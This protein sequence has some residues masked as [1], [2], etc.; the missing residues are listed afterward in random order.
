MLLSISMR[1]GILALNTC[2]CHSWDVS[3]E[4]NDLHDA[5]SSVTPTTE[6]P[7]CKCWVLTYDDGEE[8]L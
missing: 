4:I 5:T 2:Q 8:T 6:N 1:P 7:Y 3:L